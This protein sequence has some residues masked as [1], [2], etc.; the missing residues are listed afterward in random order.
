MLCSLF[1]LAIACVET[2]S[3]FLP[4]RQATR[5]NRQKQMVGFLIRPIKNTDTS[6]IKKTR[7]RL[8]DSAAASDEAVFTETE[9]VDIGSMRVSEIKKELVRL[10]V[11][12]KDCFDKESLVQRLLEARQ[13]PQSQASHQEQESPPTESTRSESESPTTTTTAT[14]TDETNASP[15]AG[16]T[17]TPTTP[18]TPATTDTQSKEQIQEEVS[19]LSVKELR[20]ELGASGIRWAGMLEKRDLVD[21]VVKCRQETAGFSVTG[22]MRPSQVT[23]LTADELTQELTSTSTL[24]LL[25]VYA[26]W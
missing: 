25:D 17:S 16:G 4:V 6:N 22:K 7:S 3:A 19:T 26:T 23:D 12:S 14:S 24:I 1:V 9:E 5:N 18:T 2:G 13:Q 21:A 11:S 15:A 8:A 10:N 20:T